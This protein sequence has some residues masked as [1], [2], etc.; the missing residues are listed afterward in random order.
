MELSAIN[1]RLLAYTLD[2]SIHWSE[3]WFN[4]IF[5]KKRTKTFA[6]LSFSTLW[7]LTIPSGILVCS[8]SS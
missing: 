4:K 2:M 6:V 1:K 7:Q 3:L 5:W 8:W